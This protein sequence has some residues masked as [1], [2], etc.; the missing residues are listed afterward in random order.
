MSEIEFLQ[1]L[2]KTG[3]N[4]TCPC[5]SNKKYKKCHLR[6]D[7]EAEHKWLAEQ[8]KARAEEAQSEESEEEETQESLKAKGKGRKEEPRSGPMPTASR[9][10]NQTMFQ[11]RT[12]R[13][14][15]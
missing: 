11:R 13:T 10:N 4:D 5:G 1:R 12:G 8:E 6:E 14:G 3:R 7:E 15:R 2:K 9:G